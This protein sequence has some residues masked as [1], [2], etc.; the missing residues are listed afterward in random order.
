MS[1][2]RRNAKAT[3]SPKQ[4]TRTAVA[5]QAARK[6]VKQFENPNVT[7]QF[8]DIMVTMSPIIITTMTVAIIVVGQMSLLGCLP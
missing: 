8:F 2:K 7:D 1:Q 3:Q 6:G 4:G 5:T